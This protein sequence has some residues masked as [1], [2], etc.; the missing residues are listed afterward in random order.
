MTFQKVACM[1]PIY[2]M[3]YILARNSAI[4]RMAKKPFV[5]FI[6]NSA[7]YMFFLG[8][9]ALASQRIEHMVINMIGLSHF[10]L[11]PSHVPFFSFLEQYLCSPRT[12]GQYGWRN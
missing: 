9:L 10:S 12:S 2:S 8:L 7:S 3:V 1:F 6:N 4:G 11:I 5:K